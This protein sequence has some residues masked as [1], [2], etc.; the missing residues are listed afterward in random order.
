MPNGDIERIAPSHIIHDRI[1][2]IF[3][4][5]FLKLIP[6]DVLKEIV[7]IR[8]K[9]ALESVR[10]ELTAAEAVVKAIDKVRF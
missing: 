6:K 4:P 7:Q 9:A 5:A 2:P 8:A 10:A 1:G 3:D